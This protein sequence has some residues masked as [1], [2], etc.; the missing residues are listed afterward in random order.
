[1]SGYNYLKEA[2]KPMAL[3]VLQNMEQNHGYNFALNYVDTETRTLIIFGQPVLS[4]S[5][6]IS[7]RFMFD[8]EMIKPDTFEYTDKL[9]LVNPKALFQ[10]I[11]KTLTPEYLEALYSQFTDKDLDQI[12]REF[13]TFETRST[14]KGFYQNQ[15]LNSMIA[16]VIEATNIYEIVAKMQ[17]LE[18][19]I[20]QHFKVLLYPY[21]TNNTHFDFFSYMQGLSIY[22]VI[23]L[24]NLS[25]QYSMNTLYYVF[26]LMKHTSPSNYIGETVKC[27]DDYFRGDFIIMTLDNRT[28][29]KVEDRFKVSYMLSDRQAWQWLLTKAIDSDFDAIKDVYNLT[30]SDLY[31]RSNEDSCR[32]DLCR[33][34]I[35]AIARADSKPMKYVKH[36]IPS[37]I[38]AILIRNLINDSLD[39]DRLGVSVFWHEEYFNVPEYGTGEIFRNML[40]IVIDRLFVKATITHDFE[41]FL[42]FHKKKN[43]SFIRELSDQSLYLA[44]KQNNPEFVLSE[45]KFDR[46][47]SQYALLM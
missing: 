7:G 11:I 46:L 38:R 16:A 4:A 39:F 24:L 6:V 8:P 36:P 29:I 20:N 9:K 15:G 47:Y 28:R 27:Y 41:D 18:L 17:N 23:R 5:M 21:R 2:I 12:P 13:R 43:T 34:V 26:T 31:L 10:E 3:Q 37:R 40:N 35:S 30:S 19:V 32:F 42:K 45:S 22:E 14:A 44:G 33:E 1:M 25:S